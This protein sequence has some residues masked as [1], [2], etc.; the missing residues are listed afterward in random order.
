[1][2]AGSLP[3]AT[4][5]Q[6]GSGWVGRIVARCM[7]APLSR[8]FPKLGSRPSRAAADT[9]SSEPPSSTR[10]T[11]RPVTAGR[12]MAA[13]T[14]SG[15]DTSGASLPGPRATS[16][17]TSDAASATLTKLAPTRPFRRPNE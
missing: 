7:A 8:I 1:V 10:S 4:V 5:V 12:A 3:V 13:S 16:G 2:R 9:K 17:S 15:R 11:T 14:S 6:T